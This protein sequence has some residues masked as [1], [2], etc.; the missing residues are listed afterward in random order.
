MVPQQTA[1]VVERLGRFNRVLS[2]G[3]NFLWPILDYCEY[4]HSLKEEV[5]QISNQM[6]ITKDSVTLHLDGVLYLKV[7][8]PKKASYGVG[9]P[10]LAMIQI[11]QTTM[12]SELGKFTLD[13]TFEERE[14][15]NAAIVNII[16]S[17]GH[18]WGIEC[19]RYEIRDITPP[20]NI[21]KAMEL[22][23]E[24][25]RQKRADILDSEKKRAAEINLAEGKK[26]ASILKAEGEAKAVVLKA[27][28]VAD[29]INTVSEAINE[30]GGENVI[31]MKLA[32]EYVSAFKKL[33]E[34][35]STVIVP[36][37]SQGIASIIAQA[38]GIIKPRI[39]TETTKH[40]V[41]Y[42]SR[43]MVKKNVSNDP[44]LESTE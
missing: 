28:S 35:N 34:Q 30:K 39:P 43:P 9:D 12:R 11:A 4:T 7:T 24:A 38:L 42:Q 17:A 23:G 21:K 31:K 40:E 44:I 36:G 33:S 14:N 3:L 37:E 22:E 25:E 2:P 41:V 10:V 18:D 8:D 20:A 29:S 27:K 32:E 6:A 26:M 15:L 19:M 13:Q 1:I 16:N 5:Y